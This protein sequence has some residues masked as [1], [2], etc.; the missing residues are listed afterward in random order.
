VFNLP[1][2]DFFFSQSNYLR[3]AMAM[4]WPKVN[5]RSVCLLAFTG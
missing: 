3:V 2:L 5:F 1:K 4:S